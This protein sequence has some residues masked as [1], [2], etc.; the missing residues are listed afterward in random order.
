MTRKKTIDVAAEFICDSLYEHHGS[1][2]R[3]KPRIILR[4]VLCITLLYELVLCGV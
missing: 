2:S 3:D 4:D 1:H